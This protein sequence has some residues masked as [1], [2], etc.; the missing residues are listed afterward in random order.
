MRRKLL[1]RCFHEDDAYAKVDVVHSESCDGSLDASCD[2]VS[3]I[4]THPPQ[5]LTVL[6]FARIRPFFTETRLG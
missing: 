2:G 3:G 4:L 6:A 5:L 1:V